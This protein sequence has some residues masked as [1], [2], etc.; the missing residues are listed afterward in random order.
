MYSEPEDLGLQS[1]LAYGVTF[2][3]SCFADLLPVAESIKRRAYELLAPLSRGVVVLSTCNRF[4][5]YLDSPAPGRSEEVIR[6]LLKAPWRLE[7]EEAAR[8]LLR[9]AAGLESQIVGED[10]VLGQVR[11]A[12]LEARRAGL[13]SELLDTVFHSAISAGARARRETRISKGVLG[14]PQAAVELGARALGDLDGRRVLVVGAGMAARAMLRHLCTKWRPASVI[15]ADRNPARAS[16]AASE[17][18]GAKAISLAEVKAIDGVDLALVA[19]KG[20]PRPELTNLRSRCKVLVDISTPPA[21]ALPD[22][23]AREIEA[24]VEESARARLEEVPKVEALLEEELDRLKAFLKRK[25]VDRYLSQIM[26]VVGLIVEE[27]ARVTAKRIAGGEDPHEAVLTALN[28]TVKRAFFPV[29]SYIREDP[30]SRGHLAREL[31]R[32]YESLLSL[33]GEGYGGV[34]EDKA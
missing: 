10:E 31:A 21:S 13:T 32:R 4:E 18:P 25:S 27:E 26:R 22:Y 5:V 16:E 34:P 20:G 14:Y 6:S 23:T 3:D 19:I 33:R 1:L 12:W 17:C 29:L 9:V 8:H 30:D 11:D 24:F 15:V 2:R 28:S 7:G